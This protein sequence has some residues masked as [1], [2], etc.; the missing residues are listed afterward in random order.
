MKLFRA[1]C[2]VGLGYLIGFPVGYCF[3]IHVETS[4]KQSHENYRQMME[5]ARLYGIQHSNLP[6]EDFQGSHTKMFVRTNAPA[7]PPP[8]RQ[9]IKNP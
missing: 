3:R 1:L 4:I 7:R 6:P 5:A 9:E 2:L 8:F